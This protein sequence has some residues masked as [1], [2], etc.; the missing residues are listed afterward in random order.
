MLLESSSTVGSLCH[1]NQAGRSHY[2]RL[3][4]LFISQ[5]PLE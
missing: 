3:K 5:L 1:L 2:K 4:P